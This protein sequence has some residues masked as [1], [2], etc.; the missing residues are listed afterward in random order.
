MA[1]ADGIYRGG[2]DHLRPEIGELHS[3]AV[4]EGGDGVGCGNHA[5]IG[6]HEAVYVGPYL[7]SLGVEQR[8]EHRGRIVASSTPEIC[9]LARVAA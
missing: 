2:I 3:L 8:C 6:G 1:D 9:D 7:Q 5:G 4:A